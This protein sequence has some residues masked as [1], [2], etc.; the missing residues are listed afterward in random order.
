[1]GRV[2]RCAVLLEGVWPPWGYSHNRRFHY[3]QQNPL[4]NSFVPGPPES[5]PEPFPRLPQFLTRLPANGFSSSYLRN[6]LLT[7]QKLYL[8][9]VDLGYPKS[10]QLISSDE[11]TARMLSRIVS[12]RLYPALVYNIEIILRLWLFTKGF[13]L[14]SCSLALQIAT[15]GVYTIWR[16]IWI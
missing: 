8:A 11:R 14:F 12:V 16:L 4:I 10:C 9:T 15:I 13:W 2:S 1:M 3:N 6:L 7:P 5:A